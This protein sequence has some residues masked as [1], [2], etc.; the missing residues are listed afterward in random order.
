VSSVLDNLDKSKF[1][2]TTM[3]GT[4]LCSRRLLKDIIYCV[5]GVSVFF[6]LLIHFG[7]A[8]IHWGS[9]TND[10]LACQVI[11]LV[12]S[13]LDG[14][15]TNQQQ[16]HLLSG[17]SILGFLFQ[18]VSPQLLNFNTLSA[19]KYMFNVLKNSGEYSLSMH[20]H[21][22]ICSH[23]TH[24]HNFLLVSCY[25]R[26]LVC[27][28]YISSLSIFSGMSEI[29]LKDALKQFYL[30]PHI[31]AYATY[32]VQRELYLFLLQYFEAEEKFL[33]L[34]C[35]LPWIIDIVHQFYSD[36]VDPSPSKPFLHLITKK[37]NEERPNMEEIRKIRLLLLSLAEMSLK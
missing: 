3:G 27:K 14:N 36:K 35:G 10:E 22:C 33:P 19:L 30:N 6:P 29:L 32:E 21:I 26:L 17:F 23:L 1:E 5:G 25:I 31:W 18:S 13:V 2:A 7:D 24:A 9:A 4:K 16:M 8:G 12:A 37:V 20:T 28:V 34:L 15:V 11:E